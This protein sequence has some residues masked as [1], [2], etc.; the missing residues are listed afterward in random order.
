M[1]VNVTKAP[2]GV[3]MRMKSR[4]KVFVGLHAPSA[5][6]KQPEGLDPE[7]LGMPLSDEVLRGKYLISDVNFEAEINLH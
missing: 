1:D 5:Q 2:C 6:Q 3:K 7:K 4:F